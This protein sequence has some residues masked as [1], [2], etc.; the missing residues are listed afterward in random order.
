MTVNAQELIT[1]AT[2]N[3]LQSRIETVLGQG[4]ADTGYGQTLSSSIVAANTVIT[5]THLQNL[6]SDIDIIQSNTKKLLD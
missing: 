1:A 5:A 6:K 2:F 4:F 3:G